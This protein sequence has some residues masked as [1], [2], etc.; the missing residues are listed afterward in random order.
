MHQAI[1]G[2]QYR[3]ASAPQQLVELRP[4]GRIQHNDLAVEHRLTVQ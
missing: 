1:E 3:F 4:A 2:V